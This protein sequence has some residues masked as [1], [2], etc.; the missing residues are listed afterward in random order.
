[1]SRF[2]SISTVLTDEEYNTVQWPLIKNTLEIFLQ[3]NPQVMVSFEQTY[4]AVYKCVCRMYGE[5]LFGD[6]IGFLR[7]YL[8][9]VMADLQNSNETD[10][11]TKMEGHVRHYLAATSGIIKCYTY[12]D[13]CYLTE[14]KGTNLRTELYN[15]FAEVVSDR[16]VHDMMTLMTRLLE[17]PMGLNPGIASS[18]CQ[19]LYTIKPAYGEAYMQIFTRYIPRLPPPMTDDDIPDEITA[20]QVAQQQ[21]QMQGFNTGDQTRKRSADDETEEDQE[22]QRPRT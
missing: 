2:G 1:M 19:G 5:Q 6:T 22:N 10:F 17:I 12:M 11:L 15:L 20:A 16:V 7:S 13:R 3:A 4:T 9:E 14:F 21:L 8:M 18:I